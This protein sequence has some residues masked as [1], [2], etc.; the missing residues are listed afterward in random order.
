MTCAVL[1]AVGAVTL[2]L[3]GC[4]DEK[5]DGGAG[6]GGKDKGA[7]GAASEKPARPVAGTVWEIQSVT[8]AGGKELKAEPVRGKPAT[9][10][11]KGDQASLRVCNGAGSAVK[12]G[13][14]SVD[15]DGNWMSTKMAC[16]GTADRLESTLHKVLKGKL[17]IAGDGNELTLKGTGGDVVRFT[18]AG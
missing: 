11:I 2:S 5:V 4:G 3:A 13:P 12:V 16:G 18:A 10:E 8:A 9:L 14:D 6:S 7:V 17:E 1:A 15:F